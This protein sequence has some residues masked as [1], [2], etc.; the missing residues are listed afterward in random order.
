MGGPH[1]FAELELG[2]IDGVETGDADAQVREELSAPEG[3]TGRV[4][5]GH[6]EGRAIEAGALVTR[7]AAGGIGHRY[8]AHAPG[9]VLHAQRVERGPRRGQL[10]LSERIA[11][12]AGEDGAGKAGGR[13]VEPG[14]QEADV[15]RAAALP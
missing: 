11:A 2:G 14:N 4:L 13:V 3:G 6:A 12:V 7:R 1:A 10:R 15:L 5:Q 9:H 8:V